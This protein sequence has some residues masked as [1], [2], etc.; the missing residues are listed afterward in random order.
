MYKLTDQIVDSI[1]LNNKIS[2][3]RVGAV[4]NSRTKIKWQCKN[5]YFEWQTTPHCIL[6]GRT[7]CPECARQKRI[8]PLETVDAILMSKNLERVSVYIDMHN[9]M[10]VKCLTCDFEW[11]ILPS[12]LL[13]KKNKKHCIQCFPKRINEKIVKNWLIN[14]NILFDFNYKLSKLNKD[15]NIIVD[16]KLINMPIII[17]YNGEQHYSPVRFG[18]CSIEKAKENFIKQIERD[19]KLEKWCQE[20]NIH[21]IC[22][23]GRKYN[24]DN[25]KKYLDNIILHIIKH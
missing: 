23:D 7:G 5:C 9:K 12:N 13:R 19:K 8:L 24:N 22:I 17:E 18:G 1:L 6:N 3:K 4:I 10:I 15:L 20:N 21:L 11:S 2:I 25:L 14:N 16:F